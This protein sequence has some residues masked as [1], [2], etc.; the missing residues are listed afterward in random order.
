MMPASARRFADLDEHAAKAAFND[1]MR[2]Y[3]KST[4]AWYRRIGAL[5]ELWKARPPQPSTP[6]AEPQRDPQHE[7]REAAY[8]AAYHRALALIPRPYT[9]EQLSIM[10]NALV[11]GASD[12]Q[13]LD[14][15]AQ[16]R[17]GVS[18]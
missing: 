16:L 13:A 3:Q 18:A 15:V 10:I 14:E 9:H 8:N 7:Q 2:G 12:E 5:V 1:F 17:Q 6:L 11:D 4:E